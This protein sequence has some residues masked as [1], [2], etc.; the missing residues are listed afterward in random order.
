MQNADINMFLSFL[1]GKTDI[2]SEKFSFCLLDSESKAPIK[3]YGKVYLTVTELLHTLDLLKSQNPTVHVN[4]NKTDGQ[5]RSKKNIIATQVL[6]V[7]IDR[8][9][10]R[11][12]IRS[13]V[14]G[15][16][17]GLVTESSPGKFHLFWKIP[18]I[19]LT[20]WSKYQE[21]LAQ[22]FGGDLNFGDITKTIRIPGI[23][24][25]TKSGEI[26]TPEI[27]VN[28]PAA[29]INSE[30][31]IGFYFTWINEEHTKFKQSK[32]EFNESF[33][34]ARKK[35]VI[36][37]STLKEPKGRNQ[38]LYGVYMHEL[39]QVRPG[40]P[41][42]TEGESLLMLEGYNSQFTD[43][44]GDDEIENMVKKSYPKA[45]EARQRKE[46]K[47][48]RVLPGA[49]TN[50]CHPESD[51]FKYDYEKLKNDRFTETTVAARVLQR[52]GHNLLRVN[53]IMYAFNDK[54][55]IWKVQKQA[56]MPEI[57]EFILL[58]INDILYDPEFITY[59]A[60][61]DS[62]EVSESKLKRAQEKFKSGRVINTAKSG[63]MNSIKVKTCDSSIFDANPELIYLANGVLNMRT[64]ELR[65][66]KA[67]DYLLCRSEVTFNPGAECPWWEKFLLEVFSDTD[68]P[69]AMVNFIQEVFGY[70]LSGHIEEQKIFCHYGDGSNGKSKVLSALFQLGGD[71]ATFIDPDEI[72]RKST[73]FSS[74]TFE[75]LGSK[76]KSKHIAIID[77]MEIKTVWNE[78]FVKNLTSDVIRGRAEYEVSKT[79]RNR[80]KVHC[81][82]NEAPSPE[83]ENMGIL[84]RLCLI[85]Y[86]KY[87]KPDN[88]VSQEIDSQ[89]KLELSGI[90][91]WALIG[92][93]RIVTQGKINYPE[94]T[95][96]A[97]EEYK[98][99][100]FSYETAIS[101][102]FESP[103]GEN[104][105][106]ATWEF[107]T[108]LLDDVKRQ[109]GHKTGKEELSSDKLGSILKRKFKLQSKK[110]W[111]PQKQ[112]ASKAYFVKMLYK[113]ANPSNF[114]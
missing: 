23:P 52:F 15:H 47:I 107:L 49:S 101:Q 2:S 81:G 106:E 64:L 95:D 79:F 92:Y 62:G 93:K 30:G 72:G 25:I 51:L 22:K 112:N 10:S 86:L 108:D 16:N 38:L 104:D 80:A 12:E 6:C 63:V 89:I 45:L 77:D 5:G 71:Y 74:K 91:N 97:L 34:K 14:E 82:L 44:L 110:I 48:N 100:F 90:L 9:T 56:V 43:P 113:R 111:N 29:A 50:G 28:N 96:T 19:P 109:A 33:K 73:S 11:E 98:E 7:D 20:H 13:I 41:V 35:G 58:C 70:S 59:N 76:I 24:R 3:G 55:K 36:D 40:A 39:T 8:E 67:A 94:A 88:K 27:L 31:E 78:A 103:Q 26:F 37:F 87:F 83:T 68:N 102:M 46:E 85:P 66:A 114:L 42:M 4:L 75:R 61:N 21:A 69:E 99:E 53:D 18:E 65:V 84:R 1:S 60:M 105:K 54:E 17:P 32:K 57:N